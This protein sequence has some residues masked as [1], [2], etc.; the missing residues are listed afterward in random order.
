MTRET[1][2][3][4]L[5]KYR[6]EET[7]D[8]LG[9]DMRRMFNPRYR[10]DFKNAVYERGLV[11]ELINRILVSDNDPIEI[12]REFYYSMDDAISTSTRSK[13]WE[14]AGTMENIASDILSYLREKEKN[15]DH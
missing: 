4:Y 5:R 9:F 6:R 15:E 1:A 11:D 3:R 8:P 14:F 13:V 7:W 10:I 2:I 12:I